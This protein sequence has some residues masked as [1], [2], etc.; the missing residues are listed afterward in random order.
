MKKYFLLGLIV[1]IAPSICFGGGARYTQLVREKQ[2]KMEELEK[3]MG[4][5]QGLKIAGLSTIGL[6]AVGVAGNIAEAQKLQEYDDAID[7]KNKDIETKQKAIVAEQEKIKKIEAEKKKAEEE[8]RLLVGVQAEIDANLGQI[9]N[10]NYIRDLEESVVDEQEEEF[11]IEIIEEE[12]EDLPE[13]VQNKMD[14]LSRQ[15]SDSTSF[16]TNNKNLVSSKSGT[17]ASGQGSGSVTQLT[18]T[19]KANTTVPP[20]IAAPKSGPLQGEYRAGTFLNTDGTSKK[21][22]QKTNGNIGIKVNEHCD[23]LK[24]Y[25]N[26]KTVTPLSNGKCQVVCKT[27]DYLD[28]QNKKC[29]S[30]NGV[31]GGP[32]LQ[33]SGVL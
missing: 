11:E 31:V 1:A 20:L 27:G 33:T 15:Q 30:K 8:A 32:L 9:Q 2:R 4:S 6:T 16:V 12:A 19:K 14:E 26:F 3:C 5:T 24:I 18:D 17:P 21:M 28:V 13:V 25:G 22:E 23:S 29:K 10:S 7:K